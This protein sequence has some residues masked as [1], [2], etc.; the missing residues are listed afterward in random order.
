MRTPPDIP[1][2]Y[3]FRDDKR[4]V[5]YVGKAKNLR[6]RV[7]SYFSGGLAPK[8][9]RMVSV[10]KYLNYITVSSEFEALLLEA[11]LVK[12][13]HPRY[14]IQLRDDKSPLYIGITKEDL[15]RVVLLRQK[16]L[17]KQKLKNVYGPFINS[18]A[19]KMVLRMLRRVF[20]FSTHKPGKRACVY[21]QL[22]LC[23][24]CPSEVVKNPEL[25]KEYLLNVRRVNAV[26]SRK[27]KKI[28][29]QLEKEMKRLAKEEKFEEAQKIKK[30]LETLIYTTT[31][32]ELDTGYIENP[33]LLEDIRAGEQESVRKI[34]SKF[35]E[36][37]KLTRIECFDVAHLSG[38]Y[39]TASMVTFINGEPD[40]SLYRH[41][42]IKGKNPAR[43]ATH[44]VAGGS[45]VDNMKE[46]LTRRFK[47]ED[48]GAPDLIIVDGGKPQV[49]IALEV[50][51]DVPVVGLAKR[52]ETLVF[53]SASG[54]EELK[55]PEG[56]AKR[57]VQR[58]RD[59]AHR[60]AR[61]YHH[62][63]VSRAIREA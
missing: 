52:E 48:W 45:D 44:S 57:L 33:N 28:T 62:K 46:V 38:T 43:N 7:R 23:D 49:S 9:A 51:I 15:P 63:L 42:R 37:K 54:F 4:K 12:K 31:R 17:G 26:L 35:Y 27:S 6:N 61:S 24:P 20:P 47:R 36:I 39:P 34:V 41:F 56:P 59:E 14:N 55:L 8:T 13:F 3:I 22:G 32:E 29:L 1:G 10:A 11:K 2:V 53:K 40:K 58:I 5:I 50:M 21:S 18:G 19:P 25:K 60:F 16:E 30:R